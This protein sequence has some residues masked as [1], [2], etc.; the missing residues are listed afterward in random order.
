MT[1]FPAS[2]ASAR[3]ARDWWNQI[4]GT[5]PEKV[6]EEPR[7]GLVQLQGLFKDIPLLM[8]EGDDRLE[9]RQLFNGPPQMAPSPPPTYGKV[10]QPFMELAVKWLS[11]KTF[12]K[13][14]RLAFGAAVTKPSSSLENCREVLGEYLPTID[15]K[16]TELRDFF[17]PGQSP[18]ILEC[19][20]WS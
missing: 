9:I 4:T 10:L 15:M 12:P 17:V 16:K 1:T 14:Q 2:R 18:P 8:I 6:I 3:L 19:N 7:K 11:L 5:P 13:L 20:Q